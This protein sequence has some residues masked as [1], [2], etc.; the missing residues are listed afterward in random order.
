MCIQHHL[1]CYIIRFMEISC[2]LLFFVEKD[3]NKGR[4]IS[5]RWI[6]YARMDNAQWFEAD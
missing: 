3:K 4:L 5:S 6:S 2:L 1:M